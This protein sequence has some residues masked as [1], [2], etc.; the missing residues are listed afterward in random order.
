M[1]D[2][3]VLRDENGDPIA[4]LRDENGNPI[5]KDSGF[6]ATI[7]TKAK[8]AMDTPTG[9]WLATGDPRPSDSNRPKVQGPGMMEIPGVSKATDYLQHQIDPTESPFYS[10]VR[11]AV[12][13]AVKFIGNTLASGFDP[14]TAGVKTPV[15]PDV[16][17]P[18]KTAADIALDKAA[19][20]AADDLVKSKLPPSKQLALP[21]GSPEDIQ[22]ELEKPRYIGGP[23]GGPGV[24]AP[25][26]SSPEIAA[27][28]AGLK[29]GGA[30]STPRSQ[31]VNL[32]ELIEKNRQD[33]LSFDQ[34][35]QYP[36][37]RLSLP[38]VE[39]PIPPES[40]DV[41]GGFSEQTN[42]EKSLGYPL[43]IVP[44]RYRPRA[45]QSEILQK[46]GDLKVEPPAG[47]ATSDITFTSGG[48]EHVPDVLPPPKPD[49]YLGTPGPVEQPSAPPKGPTQW[50]K[51]SSLED[52]ANQKIFDI[53]TDPAV[54]PSGGKF[55]SSVDIPQ[56]DDP[57]LSP[58]DAT[59]RWGYGRNAAKF[60]GSQ[61]KNQFADL[62]D[63]PDLVG[64]FQSG[65]RTGRL[66]DVAD[67]FDQRFSDL[68]KAGVLNPEDYKQNYL[69]QLWQN[70]LEEID[71]VFNKSGVAARP[72][73]SKES[74]FK[75]YQDGIDAGLTPKYNNLSDISGVFEK[76]Y[77]NAMRD[78][79]FTDYLES[80]GIDFGG[81]SISDPYSWKQI[82]KLDPQAQSMIAGYFSRSP[83]GLNKVANTLTGLKNNILSTG[84]PFRTGQVSAHGANVL[85]SDSMAQGFK[86]GLS[87]FFK[88][89]INPETDISFMKDNADMTRKLIE[90]GFNWSSI[91]DHNPLGKDPTLVDKI[92][93]LGQANIMRKKVFED[94]LFQVHLPATKLRMAISRYQ[95]LAPKIGE[96]AAL[97]ASAEFGNDFAGG[98]DKTFRNKTYQDLARIGLLAP[99]WLE[100][101]AN[102]I[103]GAYQ[104]KPGYRAGAARG[105]A[106]SA[107][108]P[109]FGIAAKG[110]G[111]YLSGKPS[112]VSGIPIGTDAKGKQRNFQPMGTAVEPGRSLLQVGSQLSQG[113]LMAPF[114]YVGNK[115]S[116]PVKSVLH[117]VQNED[118][119]GNPIAGKDKYGRPIPVMP[120]SYTKTGKPMPSALGNIGRELQ[121][122]FTPPQVQAI[123]DYASDKDS[124]EEAIVK[125]LGLPITYTTPSKR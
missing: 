81:H 6:L 106:I 38:D 12:A 114:K 67:Y 43:D 16:V 55:T 105:A 110:V 63:K 48:P 45:V 100:S 10:G 79:Q 83:S 115:M 92:P 77:T 109:T 34:A 125:A 33:K 35:S 2:D 5:K 27:Q 40:G 29:T 53:K 24:V 54:S 30:P 108:P 8:A 86:T 17:P 26:S 7:A 23:S 58:V 21:P 96:D 22:A 42:P 57:T 112:E 18:V 87:D 121:R 60:N 56:I 120:G 76:E 89:S 124:P 118:T 103:S 94:P 123:I 46:S 49:T 99:D 51:S 44:N 4:P 78:K 102:I 122:S 72:G 71:A 14:R 119:F 80:K 95:E 13:G 31:A 36:G 66:K 70:K 117:M 61:I 1:A 90:N 64:A 74:V 104:N 59:K 9:R 107:A 73:L 37:T 91:E 62:A 39:P 32:P 116:T 50:G 28:V 82:A 19:S 97:K 52:R 69:K 68:V 3:Q 15:I 101:R 41:R 11:P 75:S 84:L 88:G 65:D 111:D 47:T 25:A 98:V 85:A 93:G 20:S 113:D